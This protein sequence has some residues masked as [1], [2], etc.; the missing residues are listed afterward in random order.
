MSLFCKKCNDLIEQGARPKT[1]CRECFNQPKEE[2]LA[3]F[4]CFKCALVVE[5]E[6][7]GTHEEDYLKELCPCGFLRNEVEK[8]LKTYSE[9]KEE[10]TSPKVA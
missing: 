6:V 3:T 10:S 2:P 9:T 5:V 4:T 8:F 1:R 7:V